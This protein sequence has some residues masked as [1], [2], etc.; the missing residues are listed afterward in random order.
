[1]AVVIDANLLIPLV[2]NDPRAAKFAE[3]EQKSGHLIVCFIGMPL[4]RGLGLS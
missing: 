3:W 4:S 1:M 2:G